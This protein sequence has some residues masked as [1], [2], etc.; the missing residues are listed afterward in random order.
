MAK[1]EKVQSER[2]PTRKQAARS[3]REQEEQRRVYLALGG[4][5]VLVLLVLAFGL[6][7]TYVLEP[8]QPIATVDGTDI[9]TS[10]YQSRVLYERFMLDRQYLQ[11]QQQQA[12]LAQSENEEFVQFL[13]QQYQQMASQLLQQRSIVD[14]QTVNAMID[15]QL[16]AVE[17]AKRDI[18]VSDEEVA[19][20][21]NQFVAGQLGGL[22]EQS[23]AATEA[24]RAEAS[25]TAAA[26]TPT[27]TTITAT[28]VITPTPTPLPTATLNIIAADELSTENDAWFN[29][30]AEEVGI[31]EADYRTIIYAQV[32]RGK[33][34]DVLAEEVP[35]SAEQANARHILVETEEEAQSILDRLNDGEDF[36]ALA[37]E[38]SLDTGSGSV[39]GNLGFVPQGLFVD[40]VD[41]AVFSLPVGEISEPIQSQFG[42]HIIE[43]IERGVAELSPQD[44]QR[45]QQLALSKWLE[46]VRPEAIIQ[47]L[48]TADKAPEDIFATQF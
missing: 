47:D 36:S 42:W 20:Y 5:A 33:L 9:T 24:A 4:L 45:E 12:Q 1:K 11:I 48:W 46:Q 19:E 38:L 14:R 10:D 17:A 41:Q 22:T 16:V 8:N 18:T 25:A 32:L 21:I 29:T 31:S 34:R 40:V 26:F 30:L 13:N 39:G 15:D 3:R 2:N 35:T 7:Q 6:F 27:P 28:D 44:Y 37:Q 43:V 23:A